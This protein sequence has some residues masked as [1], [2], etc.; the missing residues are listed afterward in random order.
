MSHKIYPLPIF[1]VGIIL[2]SLACS[3]PQYLLGTPLPQEVPPQ[4]EPADETPLSTPQPSETPISPTPTQTP[5][6]DWHLI[7]NQQVSEI[8]D[9]RFQSIVE[10]PSVMGEGGPGVAEFNALIDAMVRE[11]IADINAWVADTEP[12]EGIGM[13]SEVYYSIPSSVSW[14]LEIEYV[15]P[16]FEAEGLAAAEV[17]LPA[18][19]DI[20][21]VVFVNFFYLGGAHPG[22]YH[23]TVN[24]NFTTGQPLSLAN[25]FTPGAPY[26]ERIA[27]YCVDDLNAR[28]EF[29]IWMDGAAPEP[30]NYQVWAL[31]YDGLLVVFDEYQ[32]APYA[33]GPQQ[34]LVPYD[35]LADLLH[36]QGPLAL[37]ANPP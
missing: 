7:H 10:Y 21:S 37:H 32:V 2:I 30:E 29:D 33:A 15:P 11:E 24:Y 27:D 19:H 8:P 31:T 28:L 5:A 35:V 26:L 14:G 18:D 3:L 12:M 22:S 4:L 6:P 25:L 17:L 1:W 9:K 23:W 34:V 20:I 36:P 16:H 13:F